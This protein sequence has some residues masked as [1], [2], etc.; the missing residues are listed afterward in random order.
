MIN[1]VSRTLA[2]S[3][4]HVRT[5]TCGLWVLLSLL[6]APTVVAQQVPSDPTST[7]IFPAG[8][9]R[10]TTI[11]VRVGGECLPP[12]TK[13]HWVGSGL[14]SPEMLGDKLISRG[15]PSP[16]RRPGEVHIYYPKEWQHKVDITSDAPLGMHLW[17]VAC[18]RGGTGGRPFIVGD[19]PE[20]IESESNSTPESAQQVVL[21]VTVNGQIEGERDLDYFQFEAHA[22]EVVHMEVVSRRLGSPL[23]PFVEVYDEAGNRV[24]TQL[25][26]AGSDPVIAMHVPK[27]GRYR[28]M[29]G[30]L[31]FQGGPHYVY[32]VTLST[33]PFVPFV[34][35]SGG[36]P[37]ST[38]AY[39][40]FRL[41]RTGFE[42]F[43]I[44]LTLP[45]QVNTDQWIS[46]TSSLN[47]L[48]ILPS[49]VAD[50]LEAETNNSVASA[51][52]I[53]PSAIVHGRFLE[54]E[55]EDWFQFKAT[56]NSTWTLDCRR[57]PEGG[58]CLPIMTI[59][60]ATGA[61]LATANMAEDPGRVCQLQWRAPADG[62]YCVRLRDIQQ[63][64]RGGLDFIYRLSVRPAQPT[65]ELDVAA[66]SFNVVQGSKVEIEIKAR[67][68]IDCEGEIELNVEGL[69][70]GV[71]CAPAK[72]PAGASTAK[73]QLT[74]E[75]GAQSCA[76]PITIVGRAV[77]D[78]NKLFVTARAVHLGRDS[79]GLAIGEATTPQIQLT[80]RHKPV[81]RLFC[82]EAY[83]YAY[84]G[85][86]YPYL[87]EIERLNGFTGR[88]HI[89]M[90]DRQIKDLDGIEIQPLTIEPGQTQF[91][92]PLYLPETM[93]I[94][95]QAHSNV[96]A[97]GYVLFE[98]A[99][100]QKLSQL[101]V[102]EMR[103][104]IRPLPTVAKLSSL[105]E[106]W[107]GTAGET[108]ECWLQLDRTSLFDGPMTIELID[109]PAGRGI[110][111]L[112]VVIGAGVS[113]VAIPI[114]LSSDFKFAT[115]QPL[116]FRATGQMPG[117]VS[118]VSEATAQL[119][120]QNAPQRAARV[121]GQAQGN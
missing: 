81:I 116:K 10:G 35:P 102:S 45:Q 56:K 101:F 37:G 108:T 12:L 78:T 85:S 50:V 9:R 29:I 61:A 30:H 13:F 32:R 80:V 22:D 17:R 77:G 71:S 107:M 76:V 91:Q 83:Q 7:H 40:A 87:M 79:D 55:D 36:Q 33:A 48:H 28:I 51:Q 14:K 18:A 97:Q 31:G 64:A 46:S 99:W 43:K 75:D 16:R 86:V 111:A 1:R 57:F 98:D 66:D 100:G 11:E 109:P 53:E 120:L 106:Q 39:E 105:K 38:L 52:S 72:L 3:T 89:E 23:E 84:R 26:R 70:L 20:F 67:R 63:G 121:D 54:A 4:L 90:A 6:L 93:H 73:L 62:S 58:D 96:Y 24:T 60:D 82:N 117:Y 88:V 103:C 104:M 34:F 59:T 118:I 92:L 113:S 95:V 15:E 41:G 47:P 68:S 74:A 69:P 65:F 8:G 44:D 119:V 112:P 5:S 49:A 2:L 25:Y 115:P 21:P 114:K 19:L 42:S 94:N 27:S 110:T